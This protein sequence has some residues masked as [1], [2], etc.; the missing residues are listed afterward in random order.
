[1][2]R[3]ISRVLFLLML[4]A[5]LAP[6]GRAYAQGVTTG[7]MTGVVKDAQGRSRSRRHRDS[8]CMSRPAP[9]TKRFTQRGRTLRHPR[10]ARRRSV[11]GDSVADRLHA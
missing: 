7:T 4:S 8:P 10:H 3:T 2:I 1:M 5:L 6:L 9:P 11:Q